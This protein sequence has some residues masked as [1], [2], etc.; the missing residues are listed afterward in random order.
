MEGVNTIVAPCMFIKL[1]VLFKNK[2]VTTCHITKKMINRNAM[3]NQY[4]SFVAI[5]NAHQTTKPESQGVG[6]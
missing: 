3:G 5:E 6:L 2:Y 1:F 4:K